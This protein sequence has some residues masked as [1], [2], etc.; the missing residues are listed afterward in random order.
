M[1]YTAVFRKKGRQTPVSPCQMGNA[2][3][4]CL[5]TPYLDSPSVDSVD[6]QLLVKVRVRIRVKFMARVSR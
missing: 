3:T 1:F 5:V 6:K 4:H 2:F